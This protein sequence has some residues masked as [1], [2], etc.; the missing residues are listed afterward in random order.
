MFLAIITYFWVLNTEIHLDAM[1]LGNAIKKSCLAQV[2][3]FST[4]LKFVST[5]LKHFQPN[6]IYIYN[7][8]IKIIN[9][10]VADPPQAIFG[11]GRATPRGG[12]KPFNFF[13][14]FFR[15]FF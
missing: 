13:Y 14:F 6:Y 11:G 10:G 5:H 4:Q 12:S 2:N 9:L 15:F 8:K 3:L 1:N 7:E